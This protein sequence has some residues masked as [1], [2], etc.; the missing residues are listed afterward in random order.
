MKCEAC[1]S[2][3]KKTHSTPHLQPAPL[4]LVFFLFRTCFYDH[5]CN[6]AQAGCPGFLPYSPKHFSISQAAA[7]DACQETWLL[8]GLASPFSS[9]EAASEPKPVWGGRGGEGR[10]FLLTELSCFL[11][12]PV[13]LL[14][15]VTGGGGGGISQAGEMSPSMHW[16]Q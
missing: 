11:Q 1:L 14:P 3:K 4:A 12:P 5:F 16:R 13:Y 6:Q 2:F 9:E 7:S 10:A 15:Q 8:P